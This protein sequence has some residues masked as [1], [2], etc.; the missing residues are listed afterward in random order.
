MYAQ[1]WTSHTFSTKGA[2]NDFGKICCYSTFILFYED[3]S[4]NLIR[5]ETRQTES[6]FFFI[7][8][9]GFSLI[10]ARIYAW[11]N[12]ALNETSAN[13]WLSLIKSNTT[14]THIQ[15]EWQRISRSCVVL[16]AKTDL[17]NKIRMSY[18]FTFQKSNKFFVNENVKLK[19]SDIRSIGKSQN[20]HE[21]KYFQKFSIQKRAF[22]VR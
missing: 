8:H 22:E 6:I 13:A 2:L 11:W 19:V 9:V 3:F 17:Y 12:Y 4:S 14:D 5:F 16:V 15:L 18:N 20:C 7:L 1:T 21:G 10:C